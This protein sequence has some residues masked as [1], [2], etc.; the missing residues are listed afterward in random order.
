MAQPGFETTFIPKRED[1]PRRRRGGG[2]SMLTVIGVIILLCTALVAGGF[3]MYAR[4]I[5]ASIENKKESLERSQDK[6]EPGLIELLSELDM[7]LE[8]ADDLLTEHIAPSHVFRFIE[9]ITLRSVQFT[10]FSFAEDE[11]TGGVAITL[12]GVGQSYASVALQSDEFDESDVFSDTVFS[13]INLDESTGNV[14][15]SV[16]TTIDQGVLSYINATLPTLAPVPTNDDVDD[17]ATTTEALLES[18]TEESATEGDVE[19]V[20]LEVEIEEQ[21]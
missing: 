7:R 4:V 13:G 9:G 2:G 20:P 1:A 19:V 8:N 18:D 12:S 6:F 14:Q 11:I 21:N 15:F 5:D 3:F 17:V 10:S 16:Q